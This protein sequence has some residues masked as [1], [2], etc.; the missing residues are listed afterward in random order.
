MIKGYIID[1]SAKT[2]IQKI[3]KALRATSEIKSFTLDE[4][5]WVL[6]V[7]SIRNVDSLITYAVEEI[8]FGKVRTKLSKRDL[9]IIRSK[10][11]IPPGWEI[12]NY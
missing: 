8:G 11:Y 6:I 12:E 5:G 1:I 9:D 7:D 3:R 2:D 10:R 4:S